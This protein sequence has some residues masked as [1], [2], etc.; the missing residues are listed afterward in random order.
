MTYR[1]GCLPNAQQELLIRILLASPETRSELWQKWKARNDLESLDSGSLRL[2]PLLYHRLKEAEVPDNRLT[3]YHGIYR[4]YWYRNRLL[5]KNLGDILRLLNQ[6]DIRPLLLKGLPLALEI[7]SDPALRP[8]MDMDLYI[9]PD[10][11][12]E[13]VAC[14]SEAGWHPDQLPPQYPDARWLTAVKAIQLTHPDGIA[15]DL[16]GTVLSEIADP[17]FDA[18]MLANARPTTVLNGNALSPHPTDLLFHTIAH[19]YRWNSLPPF[20]WIVDSAELL[21]RHRDEL[22]MERL[23]RTAE[24]FNLVRRIQ[25]G[26]E[27]VNRY[28]EDGLQGETSCFSGTGYRMPSWERLE[29]WLKTRDQA[30][31]ALAGNL[32]F[33]TWRWLRRHRHSRRFPE[34][35]RFLKL[36]WRVDH[37]RELPVEAI[38]RI[39]RR[40]NRKRKAPPR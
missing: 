40:I 13:A 8:M 20:R 33:D 32:L 5:L 10:K 2:L 38:R 6:L 22:D 9:V 4:H 37:S 1:G 27:R 3:K 25:K 26:I 24:Q 15:I 29:N 17:A 39:H 7:Y 23:V 28:L 16:H 36:R 30:L 12:H 18:Q 31:P 14:L 19:G 35:F 21:H 11:L 34:F